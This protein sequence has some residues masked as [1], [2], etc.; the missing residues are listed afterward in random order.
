MRSLVSVRKRASC[1]AAPRSTATS[2]ILRAERGFQLLVEPA[3]ARGTHQDLSERDR[4]GGGRIGLDED[5]LRC[6]RVRV[7][8]VEVR[9]KDAR[10]KDRQAGHSSR[11]RSR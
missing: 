10:V 8:V 7:G 11:S 1:A 6:I 3:H 9:E 4:A 5:R 2:L